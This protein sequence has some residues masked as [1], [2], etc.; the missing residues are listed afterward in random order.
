ME[1][2]R[3]SFILALIALKVK[4]LGGN[5]LAQETAAIYAKTL[6][7]DG[8]SG[9]TAVEKGVKAGMRIFKQ[10]SFTITA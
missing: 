9:A 8:K 4:N 3:L 6:L 2:N 5:R 1:T 7:R 10:S